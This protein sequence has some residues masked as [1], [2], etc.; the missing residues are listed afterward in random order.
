MI[1]EIKEDEAATTA[2]TSHTSTT[3]APTTTTTS[4]TTATTATT[5]SQPVASNSA[6]SN[7][8]IDD[9]LPPHIATAIATASRYKS[10]GNA[11]FAAG[12]Y[13]RSIGKYTRIFA[14]LNGL[15]IPQSSPAAAAMYSLTGK[16]PSQPNI[17]SKSQQLIDDLLLTANSN[18]AA[19][20]LQLE[21][22]Q[23]CIDYTTKVLNT[24][25]LHVKALRR[26][27]TAYRH[28]GRFD[29]AQIDLENCLKVDDKDKAAL[30]E[31]NKVKQG[32]KQ[33]LEKQ[34]QQFKGIFDKH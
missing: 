32:Q 4:P 17:P 31:L 5:D 27:A 1:E 16:A 10:E 30:A 6:D 3:T 20:H 11:L 25:P 28:Q 18:I 14:Y 26:R 2:N 21:Q 15:S 7:T 22:Y 23:Q 13:Q 9:V 12:E 29:D 24:D 34:R 19:A 33:Q 8:T